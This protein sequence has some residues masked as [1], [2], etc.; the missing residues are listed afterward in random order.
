MTGPADVR[1]THYQVSL[2]PENLADRRWYTIHVHYHG[3]GKWI[4]Y[5]ERHNPAASVPD[6]HWLEADGTW[7]T[8]DDQSLF[9]VPEYDLETA[10]RLA[11]EAAPK[12]TVGS[13]TAAEVVARAA[14]GQP[15]DRRTP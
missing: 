13:L 7:A 1:A 6:L 14:A 4:V 5:V 10:L 8:S 15:E 12:V 2:V 3:R 11:Q 9:D